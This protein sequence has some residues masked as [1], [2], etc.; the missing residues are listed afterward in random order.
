MTATTNFDAD[1]TSMDDQSSEFASQTGAHAELAELVHTYQAGLWRYVRYLGAD[2][3]EADDLVQET[4]LIIHRDGF[5]HRS[6]SETNAYLRTVARNRL[7]TLRRTQRRRITTVELDAA[8]SVWAEAVADDG[9]VDMLSTLDDCLQKA[10]GPKAREALDLHY[11]E[12]KSRAEI[13]E[14]LNLTA[15]GVK[16]LMRRARSALRDCLERKRS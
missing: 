7:F 12:R 2:A 13:G 11:R 6:P 8:E 14:R 5:E 1:A 3:Q 16:S 10:I 15:D 4:F 9:M